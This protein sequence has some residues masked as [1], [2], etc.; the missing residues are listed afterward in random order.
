MSDAL[1]KHV[2]S[3]RT[4]DACSG[5]DV[6]RP[7]ACAYSIQSGRSR[8]IYAD[9]KRASSRQ[10]ID[11]CSERSEYYPMSNAGSGPGGNRQ[12]PCGGSTCDPFHSATDV[13]STSAERHRTCGVDLS[14]GACLRATCACEPSVGCGGSAQGLGGSGDDR[15]VARQ[16]R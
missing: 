9:S 14:D 12:E 2:G 13:C 7:S 4:P 8:A 10:K 16:R 11:A 6:N 1:S 15:S 5:P 3:R